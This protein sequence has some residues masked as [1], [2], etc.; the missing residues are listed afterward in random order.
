M[1]G[2]VP[3][4]V[5]HYLDQSVAVD[6]AAAL[7]G[8]RQAAAARFAHLGFPTTKQEGWRSTPIGEVAATPFAVPTRFDLPASA[9]EA[10]GVAAW[11]GARAVVVNGQYVPGLSDTS[12]LPAGVAVGSLAGALAGDGSL[13]EAHLA[14]HAEYQ[15]HPFRALN[16]AFLADGAFVHVPRG[17]V[18]ETPIHM[19]FLSAPEG[20]TVSHPRALVVVEP[21][22][23]V[24]LVEH[25]LGTAPA[26][27]LANTVTE[28]VVGDGAVV[29]HYAVVRERDA[30]F[31]LA[32]RQVHQGRA[33][34]V[35]T[36]TVT[37]GGA[38]VRTDL[39]VRLAGEGAE[40]T[41]LGLYVA[42]G[43]ELVD[44]HTTVDHVVP[45][46]TSTELYK[47]IVGGRARAVFNGKV[48]VRPDAQKTDARQTN[49]NL[50]LSNDAVV[51]TRPEL[52]IFANDVKC[53]HG[54]TLGQIE[55]DQLFYL[56]ARGVPE[57][58]ARGILMHA[59][60][61]DLVE[62]VKVPALRALLDDVLLTRLPA[63]A[64][65]E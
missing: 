55:A 29:D 49:K 30:A 43:R 57:T 54:A 56:R 22:A 48:I 14:R 64:T 59:F 17:V 2:T 20:P 58:T 11:P 28:I 9:L 50:L 33:S 51:D 31:H 4:I 12:G 6:G 62:R 27:Y 61:A 18:V 25:Y 16:T 40:C 37:L 21:S 39:G 1:I 42:S 60:A 19:V 47:G 15:S 34:T 52:E 24:T 38:L 26:P 7:R 41:L 46:C 36:T 53:T 13:V 8:T 5:K 44:N 35:T 65:R 3:E 32:S 10:A 45:R 23:Q 63:G